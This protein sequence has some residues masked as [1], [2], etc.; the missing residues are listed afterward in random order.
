[1]VNVMQL[2]AAHRLRLLTR[3]SL[4]HHHIVGPKMVNNLEIVDVLAVKAAHSLVLLTRVLPSPHL[5]EEPQ[6][7]HTVTS[8]GDAAHTVDLHVQFRCIVVPVKQRWTN[9]RGG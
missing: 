3:S 4:R 6:M 5:I 2:T 9:T 1:M 8:V 7:E